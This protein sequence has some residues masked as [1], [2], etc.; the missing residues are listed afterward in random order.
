MRR[1]VLLQFSCRFAVWPRLVVCLFVCLQLVDDKT[2]ADYN[3]EGGATVHLVCCNI[4]TLHVEMLHA[5]L[6]SMLQRLNRACCMLHAA[7]IWCSSMFVARCMLQQLY[8]PCCCVRLRLRGVGGRCCDVS[9][10]LRPLHANVGWCMHRREGLNYMH[11]ARPSVA[12]LCFCMLHGVACTRPGRPS[13]VGKRLC[14]GSAFWLRTAVPCA[15]REARVVA[16]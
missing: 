5:A 4:A 6:V 3:L 8:F 12:C 10:C 2:A 16:M 15:P 13:C 14:H 1:T 9:T 7:A 11:A